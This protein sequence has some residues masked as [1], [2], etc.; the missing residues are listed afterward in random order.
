ML[1][2]PLKSLCYYD[3]M[4]N[5]CIHYKLSLHIAILCFDSSFILCVCVCIPLCHSTSVEIRGQLT[6]V[7][8]LSIHGSKGLNLGLQVWEHEPLPI[9]QF[10]HLTF[11]EIL[12]KNLKSKHWSLKVLE[13]LCV[14][15]CFCLL[16]FFLFFLVQR[17]S[18]NSFW[19]M[20]Y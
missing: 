20:I 1:L 4:F 3:Q 14:H 2:I 8:S 12:K 19:G 10:L 13:F 16:L 6:S 17:T 5:F 11:I 9:D 15:L 7:D 18:L